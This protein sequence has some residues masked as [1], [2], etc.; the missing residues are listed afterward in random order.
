MDDFNAFGSYGDQVGVGR[1]RT[2]FTTQ[3][4]LSVTL[5]LGA[6]IAFCVRSIRLLYL[7]HD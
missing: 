7:Q 5:G 6:F 4:V 2:G 1:Q 3:L